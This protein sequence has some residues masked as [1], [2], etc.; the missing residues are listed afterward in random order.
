L[1]S[2]RDFHGYISLGGSP[3]GNMYGFEC[4]RK[5]KEGACK[6]KRCMTPTICNELNV[7]H[8]RQTLMFEKIR[9]VRGVK[10]VFNTSGIRHDLV[11]A[12]IKSGDDY[13]IDLI[14]NSISGQLKIAPEHS[15]PYVLEL[16]GKPHPR[17][18]VSFANRFFHLVRKTDKRLYLTYYLIAAHPGCEERDMEDLHEFVK[19]NLNLKPEQV[20]VYTPLPSTWSALMYYTETNPFTGNKIFVEKDPRRKEWQKRMITE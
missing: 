2:R 3:T 10:K 13:M 11:L 17:S 7:N 14:E 18:T 5:H 6:D 20:Q 4:S 19:D 15:D 9:A 1:A 16:M 12:D 8:S